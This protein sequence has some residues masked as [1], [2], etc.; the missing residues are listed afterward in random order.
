RWRFWRNASPVVRSTRRSSRKS[1]RSLPDCGKR[2]ILPPA[3]EGAAAEIEAEAP[4]IQQRGGGAL[5][6]SCS[7]DR[8]LGR[9]RYSSRRSCA[10]GIDGVTTDEY[11]TNLDA[12]LLDLPGSHQRQPA[13]AEQ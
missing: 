10:P 11:A 8:A 9:S 5:G 6:C 1:V 13:I 7:C 2:P 12:N 4:L 3:A